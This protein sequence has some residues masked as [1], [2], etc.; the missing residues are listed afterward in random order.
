MS[1]FPLLLLAHL[2][3]DFILQSDAIAGSKRFVIRKKN[4]VIKLRLGQAL[5]KHVAHHGLTSLIAAMLCA[6]FDH[7]WLWI[8]VLPF[9]ILI[10]H[11]AI[12]MGN[13]AAR[14]G[15]LEFPY[16]RH[17][18]RQERKHRLARKRDSFPIRLSNQAS[19]LLF[20][21]DQCMHIGVIVLLCFLYS[22]QYFQSLYESFVSLISDR[23]IEL[24]PRGIILTAA[25]VVICA[26]FVSG[27]IVKM[28]T[29]PGPSNTP[30]SLAKMVKETSKWIGEHPE[31][32]WT[33]EA[34][35]VMDESPSIRRGKAI[36]YI[37][38]LIVIVVIL[39]GTYSAIAFIIAAKSLAR[40]K[41]LDQ[42]DWAEYFLMG[43]LTS[44]FLGSLCGLA[45]KYILNQ[46]GLHI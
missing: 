29:S 35:Y 40:F 12:D 22:S 45:L 34:T 18:R 19:L 11:L 8:V 26:T 24:F 39:F 14:H 4:H 28:V 20:V 2:I 37:E 1:L 44:I 13:I 38:R 15:I 5:Q 10:S 23:Y 6:G 46:G 41:K 31:K 25:I 9:V 16:R 43:T 42:P 27:S 3:S 7:R 33:K 30:N 32:E 36:G 21:I 17:V